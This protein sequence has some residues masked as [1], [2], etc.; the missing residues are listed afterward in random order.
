MLKRLLTSLALAFALTCALVVSNAPQAAAYDYIGT[1]NLPSSGQYANFYREVT[2][3]GHHIWSNRYWSGSNVYIGVDVN[4]YMD[5]KTCDWYHIHQNGIGAYSY[6]DIYNLRDDGTEE[7]GTAYYNI[8]SVMGCGHGNNNNGTS[9]FNRI[10]VHPTGNYVT[11]HSSFG[12]QYVN[13]NVVL[14]STV[15]SLNYDP[16]SSCSLGFGWVARFHWGT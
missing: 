13:T 3:G 15:C 8:T 1:M 7:W 12:G 14:R 11:Y 4:L 16:Y 2:A 9:G 5:Y 10:Q 6:L